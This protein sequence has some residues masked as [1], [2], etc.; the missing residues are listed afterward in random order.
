MSF[1]K[2]KVD[3]EAMRAKASATD[4]QRRAIVDGRKGGTGWGLVGTFCALSFAALATT[5]LMAAGVVGNPFAK[6]SDQVG[7]LPSKPLVGSGSHEVVLHER[8]P[9]TPYGA[10]GR[11]PSFPQPAE[12]RSSVKRRDCNDVSDSEI[13]AAV[14]RLDAKERL[15]E[16]TKGRGVVGRE[17]QGVGAVLDYFSSPDFDL[18]LCW[19]KGNKLKKPRKYRRKGESLNAF[20][21]SIRRER[22]AYRK[23]SKAHYARMKRLDRLIRNARRRRDRQRSGMVD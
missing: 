8:R 22:K 17:L 23:A 3:F 9:S 11:R 2:A 13:I 10:G 4:A 16:A 21:Q 20:K 1:G 19:T 5:G 18:R 14:L 7:A 12:A 6:G 15:R